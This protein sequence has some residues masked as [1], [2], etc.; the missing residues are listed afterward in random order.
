MFINVVSTVTAVLMFP[1]WSSAQM[2]AM[3]LGLVVCDWAGHYLH[4]GT[5]PAYLIPSPGPTDVMT[6]E[7]AWTSAVSDIVWRVLMPAA[8]NSY[9]MHLLVKQKRRTVK[10]AEASA[11]GLRKTKHA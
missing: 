8:V 7:D 9:V 6:A 10:Q 4:A 3:G 5:I 11:S 2:L 1:M